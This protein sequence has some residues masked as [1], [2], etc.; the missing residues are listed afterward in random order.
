MTDI[1]EVPA[2]KVIVV[3]L[4]EPEMPELR[5]SAIINPPGS[6]VGNQ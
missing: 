6:A 1:I 3:D 5:D 2:F 4:I